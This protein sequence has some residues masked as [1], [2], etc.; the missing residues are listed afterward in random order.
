MARSVAPPVIVSMAVPS[1]TSVPVPTTEIVPP[2][3]GTLVPFHVALAAAPL[4]PA[5]RY[6]YVSAPSAK[7]AL[8]AP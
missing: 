4:Q 5:A 2:V 3:I 1:I 6:A 8:P 7:S